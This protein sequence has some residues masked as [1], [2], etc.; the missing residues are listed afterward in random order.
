MPSPATSRSETYADAKQARL[1]ELLERSPPP[2]FPD[3]IALLLGLREAG[4]AIATASASRNASRLLAAAA[5]PDGR[6]LAAVIDVDVSGLDGPGKPDPAMF[7]EAAR[8]L[9][10]VPEACLVGRGRAG[11]RRGRAPRRHGQRSPSIAAAMPTRCGPAEPTSCWS[12]LDSV[13]PAELLA[14]LRDT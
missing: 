11:R 9:D 10:R 12:R 14:Q 3:A 6:A 8:R 4:L 1:L 2:V 13:P 7:L 5:L